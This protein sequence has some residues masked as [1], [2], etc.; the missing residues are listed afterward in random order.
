MGI[1]TLLLG[2]WQRILVY[3]ALIAAALTV[4]WFHGLF[5]GRAALTEYKAEQATKAAQFVVKVER[6]KE[7]V[8]VPYIKRVVELQTRYI[9]IE[10]E[11][12]SVPNRP[13][14]NVT[15]GWMRG[16]NNAAD[17]DRREQGTVDDPADTGIGEAE[18]LGT[19]TR[20]YGRYHQV[21]ADL[22]ACRAFVNKLSKVSP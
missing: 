1:L 4:V 19:V 18:A 15:F 11:N 20:N 2:N 3:A 8:R 6:V 10:K 21:V 5:T 22:K 14:C 13:Q 16:H 7:I 17:P 12:A 9:T